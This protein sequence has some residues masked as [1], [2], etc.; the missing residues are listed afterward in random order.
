M[1]KRQR[2]SSPSPF[3]AAYGDDLSSPIL[4]PN[5]FHPAA[6]TST[7]S[8]QVDPSFGVSRKR[9][10]LSPDIIPGVTGLGGGGSAGRHT[11]ISSSV[12][13]KRRRSPDPMDDG[14]DSEGDPEPWSGPQISTTHS[15]YQREGESLGPPKRRRTTAPVLEGSS[16]GWGPD[17][18]YFGIGPD[19]PGPSSHPH[20]SDSVHPPMG[21]VLE[22]QT[23]EYA[24]ENARLHDLH[25]LRPRLPHSD[26]VT[27][28]HNG[29]AN[30]DVDMEEKVVKERY[31][32]H[33]KCVVFLFDACVSRRL[34]IC[35]TAWISILGTT[36][37][38]CGS[39]KF[40]TLEPVT[41]SIQSFPLIPI[42]SSIHTSIP[43]THIFCS[44]A[45]PEC[46]LLYP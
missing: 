17:Q 44:S 43:S 11:F 13:S 19:A 15:D 26:E 33:N 16:R 28:D 40:H 3:L 8:I 24:H 46:Y 41:L 29:V 23:G 10:R 35:Q 34:I 39:M 14:D 18:S 5:T 21:W 6:N 22:T 31:E 4:G 42:H 30:V 20:S 45:R 12:L 1:L 7:P 37:K 25:T 38:T 27:Q 32:E 36:T 2:P 9:S